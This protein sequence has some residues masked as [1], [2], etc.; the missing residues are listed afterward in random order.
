MNTSADVKSTAYLTSLVRKSWVD[1]CGFHPM[2]DREVL[3]HVIQHAKK[4]KGVVLLDLDSTLYEVG[5]RTLQILREFKDSELS[6]PFVKVRA[7]LDAM[8]PSQIGYSLADTFT[9]LG[10]DPK[11][12]EDAL[13]AGKDFWGKRFFTNEYLDFD[14][15]YEGAPEFVREVYETGAE[16][17]YLTGRDEPG[18]G[19]GTRSRLIRDGFPF[20]RERTH[21]LLKENFHLDDL[22]HK[23][24]AT[25]YV[26]QIGSLIASFE[27][28]PPNV[29][30][31]HD[32]FPE[33]LHVFMDTVYSDR[34]ADPRNGLY[35]I[36]SFAP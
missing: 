11:E 21:L 27:N 32:I 12:Q 8:K 5:P 30:A 23:S 3:D 10:L 15:T 7:A 36:T 19:I 28:E 16:I 20:D 13:K 18:M 22:E 17:I 25:D 2:T 34:P 29:V 31:I 26:K 9:H 35:R 1:A 33:S 14:H 6:R 4:M 24:K